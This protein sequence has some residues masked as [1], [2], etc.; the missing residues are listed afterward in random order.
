MGMCENCHAGCCRS[1]A[2]PINGADVIRLERESNLTF[3][4]FACRWADPQGEIAGNYAPHF[5]FQDEPQTPFVICLKQVESKIHPGTQ[6]CQFLQ[7]GDKSEEHPRGVS[8]C[9]MYQ[10]RPSACRVFPTKYDVQN[11][12]PIL[13]TIPEYGREEHVPAYKLCPKQWA[14][15][16]VDPL[17]VAHELMIARYEVGFFKRIAEAWNRSPKPWELFPAFLRDVYARRIS[18][19]EEVEQAEEAA[20]QKEAPQTIKL[21]QSDQPNREAA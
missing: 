13:H 15:E 12:L 14:K 2:I 11:E 17:A 10:G 7:E 5:H 8:R 3:W 9:G 1:Y 21:Y 20:M 6:C 4:E 19:Q 18:T 16:D